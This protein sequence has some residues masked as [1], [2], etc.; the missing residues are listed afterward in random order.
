MIIDRREMRDKIADILAMLMAGR[1]QI[2]LSPP[3][4]KGEA[5]GTGG[6]EVEADDVE[7]HPDQED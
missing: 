4:T 5:E 2:P 3:L 6:F 7:H 1:D